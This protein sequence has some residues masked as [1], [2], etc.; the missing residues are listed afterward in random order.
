WG[1]KVIAN[2]VNPISEILARSRLNVPELDSVSVRLAE[3]EYDLTL[4]PDID[5]S[6]FYEDQTAAEIMSLKV[7]L[8]RQRDAK[9][10]DSIDS[11]IRMVA[12]NRL[13]GHSPGFFSVYT[14]PPN[15]AVSAN[16]QIKIN[17]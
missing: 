7:Y 3:I 1:R 6:M 8:K 2:D 17:Q 13:T 11:W 10:E 16:S 5:L 15:Q 9:K 14:F 12:T 4:R